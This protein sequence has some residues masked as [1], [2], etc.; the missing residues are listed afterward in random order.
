MR[1]PRDGNKNAIP[2]TQNTAALQVTNSN[3]LSSQV[4]INLNAGTTLLEINALAQAVFMKYST[5]VTSSSFD[6]FIQAGGVRHYIVPKNVTQ[7]FLIE[8]AASAT[9]IVIEK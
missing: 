7:I 4:T 2:L 9:V 5:G 8:Q 6:E 3:A 1:Q